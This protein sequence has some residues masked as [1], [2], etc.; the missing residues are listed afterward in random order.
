M[1]GRG[2]RVRL[3][4][5]VLHA[6]ELCNIRRMQRFRDR[7]VFITGASSGIGA[8]LAR[9]FAREGADLV[10]TAR[11]RDRLE[12]VARTL[13]APHASV[14]V[15]QCDV[16]KDGELV[17]AVEEI[18]R[19][20][21]KIDVVVANAGYGV[22]GKIQNLAIDDFRRQLETNVFGVLRTIYATLAELG[23]TRGQL[24]IMG[25]VAGYVPQPGVS[26]YG[27]SKFAVRALAE[28][29]RMDLA[30]EGIAVTLISPGFVD[31]DIRRTD[32]RGALHVHAAD[33]VPAWVR[34]PTERAA[35]EIVDAVFRKER[36]RIITFHGR[37][38]VFVYRHMPWL[39]RLIH[40]MGLKGRPEPAA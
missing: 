24:V 12:E 4:R 32:N 16:T 40:R 38:V 39:V 3:Q 8:A 15:F 21:G 26:P 9:C 29:A 5:R 2:T 23:R 6:A 34:V 31:S 17:S 18:K 35:R 10:L 11:R 33:P 19:A 14:R 25:S 1:L 20:G 7:T 30:G 37:F 27:M 13:P 22:V 36:E 28:S